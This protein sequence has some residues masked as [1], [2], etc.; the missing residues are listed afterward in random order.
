MTHKQKAFHAAS[1]DWE[2]QPEHSAK[3]LLLCFTEETKLN[4]F[5]MTWRRVN[6]DRMSIWIEFMVLSA[7]S[8]LMKIKSELSK[9]VHVTVTCCIWLLRSSEHILVPLQQEYRDTSGIYAWKYPILKSRVLL[10]TL[11]DPKTQ[12]QWQ[13]VGVNDS[14][15]E[16]FTMDLQQTLMKPALC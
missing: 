2:E 3:R 15:F 9:A 5:V 16:M 11:L 4:D 13:T 12:M 6:D 1:F 7:Q 10:V 8:L 14:S